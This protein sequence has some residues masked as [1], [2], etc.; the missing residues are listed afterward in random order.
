MKGASW[1]PLVFA[2]FACDGAF[3]KRITHAQFEIPSLVLKQPR[4]LLCKPLDLHASMLNTQYQNNGAL[5]SHQRQADAPMVEAYNDHTEI[6][7]WSWFRHGFCYDSPLARSSFFV[8]EVCR[9]GSAPD[10][11]EVAWNWTRQYYPYALY[12]QQT[13]QLIISTL[14]CRLPVALESIPKTSSVV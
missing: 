10:R 12:C 4:A 11:P 8:R 14:V 2:C 7:E 5:L 1:K 9:C 6:R 3:E 13:F